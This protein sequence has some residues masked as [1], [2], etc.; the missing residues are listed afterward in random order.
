MTLAASDDDGQSWQNL[1]EVEDNQ[2]NYC[3]T[4]MLFLDDKLLLTE[5]ESEN[6]EDGSRRNLAYFKMQLITGF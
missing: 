4:S 5:Y 1:G 6:K 2:H 3:Y